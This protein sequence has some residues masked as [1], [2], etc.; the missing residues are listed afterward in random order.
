MSIFVVISERS[1][2]LLF[3]HISFL[4]SYNILCTSLQTLDYSR[5]SR[6]RNRDY[7]FIEYIVISTKKL[8]LVFPA[9]NFTSLYFLFID[10]CVTRLLFF[11]KS[12]KK[13]RVRKRLVLRTVLLC[14]VVLCCALLGGG[15]CFRQIPLSSVV[16]C[17]NTA[18]R[19]VSWE[20][21]LWLRFSLLNTVMYNVHTTYH[22]SVINNRFKLNCEMWSAVPIL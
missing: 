2:D 9:V 8:L 5:Q 20:E 16:T 17:R 21:K 7:N 6:N 3:N 11:V 19:V 15:S 1:L 14:Y 13:K 10:H 12:G 22:I 18:S 4:I